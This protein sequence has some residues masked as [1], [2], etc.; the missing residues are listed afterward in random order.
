MLRVRVKCYR[1]M[2]RSFK[3]ETFFSYVDVPQI[4]LVEKSEVRTSQKDLR[5]FSHSNFTHV[6]VIATKKTSR[7]PNSI[8][9]GSVK[10]SEAIGCKRY[11]IPDYISYRLLV[12]L[13]MDKIRKYQL[14]KWKHLLAKRRYFPNR[15]L[16]DYG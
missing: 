16:F 6:L 5:I 14:K 13:R 10:P 8:L 3:H 9:F 4:Y 11:T 15:P 2:A 7:P 12:F 1:G